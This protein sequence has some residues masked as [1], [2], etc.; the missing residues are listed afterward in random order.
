MLYRTRYNGAPA[1]AHTTRRVWA[2]MSVNPLCR[3][4]ELARALG[5]GRHTL[6]AAL[7]RLREAGYLRLDGRAGWSVVVPFV[8]IGKGGD[9]REV[10]D[11]RT[12]MEPRAVVARCSDQVAAAPQ[13]E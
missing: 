8:V 11:D 7:Y 1:S 13:E 5:I 6:Y 10:V 9:A 3:K 12:V 4:D 2:A